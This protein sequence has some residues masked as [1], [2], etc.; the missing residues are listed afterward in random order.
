VGVGD[1][2]EKAVVIKEER[3]Q[4][5]VI[6]FDDD[7]NEMNYVVAALLHAVSDLSQ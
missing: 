3:V 7:Y 6:L 2:T 4:R 5:K 1:G